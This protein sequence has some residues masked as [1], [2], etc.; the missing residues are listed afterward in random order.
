MKQQK[1]KFRSM[2]IHEHCSNDTGVPCKD[3]EY[4]HGIDC[5]Y[6]DFYLAD[7][8]KPYKTKG[9]KYILIEVKE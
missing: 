6:P 5:A 1:R 4:R 7:K 2:T 8:N 3:C 9:G